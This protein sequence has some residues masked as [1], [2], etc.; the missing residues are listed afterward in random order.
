[1]MRIRC[2]VLA[3]CA[4]CSAAPLC[5]P[6]T[7][8][9]ARRPS[10]SRPTTRWS[11]PAAS[12][13]ARPRGQE[14]QLR[15]VAVVLGK[16]GRGQGGHRGLRRAVRHARFRRSGAWR[17][18]KNRPA[19]RRPACWST[20]RTRTTPPARPP[21]TATCATTCSPNAC[22]TR[23][24]KRSKQANAKLAGGDARVL[25]Q[26]GRRE[27]GRR[28]QP[29]AA[30]PTTRSGGAGRWTTPCATPDRSIR[31]CRCWPFAAPIRSCGP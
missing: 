11:S 30:C 26:A 4:R 22:K 7:C 16:A 21:C 31:N 10:I 3:C 27:H 6:P 17:R 20:P 25:L 19:F 29:R 24:S 8:A 14:G 13:R 5:R 9:S 18:S 12:G 28:Q 23:S 15:A 2:R 1:M